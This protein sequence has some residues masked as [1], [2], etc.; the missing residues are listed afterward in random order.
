[1]FGPW[2]GL[3]LVWIGEL[4]LPAVSGPGDDV[5][6][7]PVRQQLQQ[8]LPQLYRACRTTESGVLVGL[9]AG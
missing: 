9:T 5:L 1:L 6:Q 4:E 3:Y 7:G 8:K 2:V